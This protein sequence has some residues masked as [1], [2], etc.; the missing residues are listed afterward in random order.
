MKVETRKI[1][2]I[3][4]GERKRSLKEE[5]VQ[6]LAESISLL[7]LLQPIGI[8]NSN[9]LIYGY[10]R[11]EACKRLGWEEIPVVVLDGVRERLEYEL[12][13]I[14]ENLI[15]AE[16]TVLQRMVLLKRR[17]EIYEKLHPE[18]RKGYIS[19]QNLMQFRKPERSESDLSV[20]HSVEHKGFVAE[21]S[22]RTG[23]SKTLIKEDIQIATRL[24][25]EVKDMIWGTELEDR[26]TDL[27]EISRLEPEEQKYVVEKYLNEGVSVKKAIQE[28]L[29]ERRKK[30]IEVNQQIEGGEFLLGDARVLIDKLEDNSVDVVITDPPYGIEFK[31][32][33]RKSVNLITREIE[34]DNIEITLNLLDDVLSKLELK[35]KDDGHLYLFCTWKT[36]PEVRRVVEKYFRIKTVLIWVKEDVGGGTIGDL[37]WWG[38]SYE[39]VIGA[40][41]KNGKPRPLTGKRERNVLFFPR[42]SPLQLD[43]PAQKP[44]ELI[45]F[46]IMKTTVE[47][48][49]IVD[50]FAGVGTTLISAK[51]LNRRFWGCEIDEVFWRIGVEKLCK[52]DK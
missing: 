28:V 48:E 20:K 23:W 19:L 16:L 39:M 37:N 47:G 27:L 41:K 17:K 13:E 33:R 8:D 35:L 10:H 5:K 36:Y 51:K 6:E 45:E 26:R 24:A 32:N 14:D 4:V 1:D 42:V 43:H 21:V 50:P 52:M 46:L 40:V 30:E 44:T 9:N 29:V 22:E 49:L 34:N 18:T 12:M 25:D 3:K 38:E 11:L 31:S 7:G 15:R 2:E